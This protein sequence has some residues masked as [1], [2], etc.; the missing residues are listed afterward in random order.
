[1]ALREEEYLIVTWLSQYGPMSKTMFRKLL[2]HKTTDTVGRILAG[3]VRMRR[4]TMIEDHRF[5]ALDRYCKVE[6][7]MHS[8]IWVLCQFADSITLGCHTSGD[9][10]SQIRFLK[11]DAVYEI[12]VLEQGEEEIT[13]LLKPENNKVYILV[14]PDM[15]F[16]EK[17]WLPDTQCIFATLEP[18]AHEAPTVTF[19][20]N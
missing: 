12:I 14:V 10:F 3:L 17:L 11:K 5:Y 4:I 13:R 2:P 19:Y 8:A 6:P 20:S 18:S 15:T 9:T 16:A 1:M 7:K